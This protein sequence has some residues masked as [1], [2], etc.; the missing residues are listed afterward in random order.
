M[1]RTWV[2]MGLA[3][4]LFF[5]PQERAVIDRPEKP[6]PTVVKKPHSTQIKA[7]AVIRG[8][9]YLVRDGEAGGPTLET[10]EQWGSDTGVNIKR[11][12]Q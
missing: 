10:L 8:S 7:P 5:S 11:V 9:G 4:T 6:L 2:M 3:F 1:N 12:T